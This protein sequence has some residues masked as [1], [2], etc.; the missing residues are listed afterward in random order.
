VSTKRYTEPSKFAIGD[1]V[2]R[3]VDVYDPASPLKHGRVVSAHRNVPGGLDGVTWT[4]DLVYEVLWDGESESRG[5]YFPHGLDPEGRP[6][7][8]ASSAL[9]GFEHVPPVWFIEDKHY[10]EEELEELVCPLCACLHQEDSATVLNSLGRAQPWPADQIAPPGYCM[11][12]TDR[13]D[14]G[15]HYLCPHYWNGGSWEFRPSDRRKLSFRK[16]IATASRSNS[17]K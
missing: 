7:E 5:G 12:W 13:N 15:G 11:G 17:W 1:R 2:T 4:D 14:R 9:R 10:P 8:Y 16:G 6:Q 3:P